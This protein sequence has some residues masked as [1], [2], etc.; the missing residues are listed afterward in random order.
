MDKAEVVTPKVPLADEEIEN[1]AKKVFGKS[2]S[3]LISYQ[4]KN[5]SDVKLGFSGLHCRLNLTVQLNNNKVS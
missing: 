2:F 1:I 3:K 4:L 5:Y